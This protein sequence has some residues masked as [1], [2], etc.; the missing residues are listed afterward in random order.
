MSIFSLL[1]IQMCQSL[2]YDM[3]HTHAHGHLLIENPLLSPLS[4]C[5]QMTFG[6]VICTLQV[7]KRNIVKLYDLPMTA[8]EVSGK[9]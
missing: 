4:I 8:P 2:H 9:T 6:K 3:L 1:F 7:G 5:P